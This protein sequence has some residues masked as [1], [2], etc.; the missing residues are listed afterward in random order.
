MNRVRLAVIVSLAASLVAAVPASRAA[1][2]SPR[3]TTSQAEAPRPRS[4]FERLV[5]EYFDDYFRRHPARATSA[6]IHQYDRLLEDYSR[7]AVDSTPAALHR[8][9][10]RFV[11]IDP[12]TPP[13]SAA[14]GREIMINTIRGGVRD[15]REGQPW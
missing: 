15:L 7:S 3:R 5:D 9:E 2:K 4:A 6:G 1:S 11:A 12:G 10:A 8:F 14:A 13:A